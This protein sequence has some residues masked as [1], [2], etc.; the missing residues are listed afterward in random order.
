MAAAESV[1][2]TIAALAAGSG[3]PP[4][5]V[6]ILKEDTTVGVANTEVSTA[7][8]GPP[9]AS[10]DSYGQGYGGVN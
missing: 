10:Q 5:C 8:S 6:A 9:Q 3:S 2:V 4:I 7:N 1:V